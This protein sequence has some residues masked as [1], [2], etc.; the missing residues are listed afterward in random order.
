MTF[1]FSLY[2]CCIPQAWIDNWEWRR[3]C[4]FSCHDTVCSHM[5]ID[6][7]KIQ[8]DTSSHFNSTP[9][10]PPPCSMNMIWHIQ[11]WTANVLFWWLNE[12]CG[13]SQY[14]EVYAITTETD[15]V[16]THALPPRASASWAK[17]LRRSVLYPAYWNSLSC[18]HNWGLLK[19]CT[20]RWYWFCFWR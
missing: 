6:T 12:M 8:I 10:P 1:Y 2:F 17:P 14:L 9:S 20:Y 18:L 11:I 3:R 4:N 5:A 13:N 16:M 7:F 15:S 19:P